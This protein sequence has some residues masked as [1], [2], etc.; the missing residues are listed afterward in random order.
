MGTLLVSGDE[1]RAGAEIVQGAE[2]CYEH[3]VNHLAELGFPKGVLP[4]RDLEECGHVRETGFVWMR[5]RAPFEYYFKGTG[6]RVSYD[7]E[8]TAYVEKGKMKRM[9]GVKSKQ[10]L[11]WVP[12]TEM[13]VVPPD[14]KK[15]YFKTAIGIGR[16]FPA[17]AFKEEEEEE[18]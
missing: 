3:S 12:I 9:T 16:A 2:A 17:A 14:G 7:R 13:S 10:M 15:I 4:L 5:Q 1:R 11:L 18:N 8:V 6:T